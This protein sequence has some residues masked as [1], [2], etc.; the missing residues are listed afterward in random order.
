MRRSR[1][2]R[3]CELGLGAR[4]GTVL[5]PVRKACPGRAT[6]VQTSDSNFA[7]R[8]KTTSTHEN[9]AEIESP[10][11]PAFVPDIDDE[12]SRRVEC[13]LPAHGARRERGYGGAT[14]AQLSYVVD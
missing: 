12:P 8:S 10:R 2:R 9:L 13:V 6:G 3:G 7:G 14:G 4:L 11:L 1:E 5:L